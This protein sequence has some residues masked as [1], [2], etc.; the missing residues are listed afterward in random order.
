MTKSVH[1]RCKEGGG[2]SVRKRPPRKHP[3]RAKR[4]YTKRKCQT[5]TNRKA[6]GNHCGQLRKH[7]SPRC[8][9]VTIVYGERR[10]GKLRYMYAPFIE[11]CQHKYPKAVLKLAARN[12]YKRLGPSDTLIFIGCGYAV[13]GPE[14]IIRPFP[15]YKQLRK[16]GVHTIVFW[17]EPC[18]CKQ[19]SD[20]TWYYS[21]YLTTRHPGSS[22][23]H[24]F[25]KDKPIID[26]RRFS[27]NTAKLVFLGSLEYR[28]KEVANLMRSIP[29][30]IERYD[31][32]TK[33]KFDSFLVK[34]PHIYVSICKE[35]SCVLPSARINRLLS[36]GAI[37]ISQHCNP[38]DD[39]LYNDLIWFCSLD[40]IH[41]TSKMLMDKSPRE[42]HDLSRTIKEVAK[43]RFA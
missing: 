34:V 10:D 37:I 40:E 31:L 41:D 11:T 23:Q 15:N 18:V 13:D 36:S 2:R 17:T 9:K 43:K 26:Y 42:L 35:G 19:N 4:T 33:D 16:R 25:V 38:V 14:R 27:K 1:S 5:H 29:Y 20:E 39:A 32:F 8:K 6:V 28:S 7:G 21:K 3:T 30:F 24:L 22:F 12:V